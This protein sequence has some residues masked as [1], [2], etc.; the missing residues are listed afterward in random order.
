MFRAS[1]DQQWAQRHFLRRLVVRVLA[2]QEM[3]Q[4]LRSLG[5][6]EVFNDG[7][8]ITPDELFW[9]KIEKGIRECDAFVVVLSHALV[10]SYWVDSEVQFARDNG[11]KVIPVRIDDCKLPASFD[12]RDVIDLR[13]GRDYKVKLAPSRITKHSPQIL[14]GRNHW[15]DALDAAWVNPAFRDAG[16]MDYLPSGLLTAALYHFVRG[17]AAAARTALDQ[18][19]QIAERGPMPLYL[20]D[21]HLHR[22]RFF[23]DNSERAKA[24]EL[25]EKHG[26]GRRKEELEDAEAAAKSWP[27]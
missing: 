12:G 25:I 4:Y 13:Q 11:K 3:V 17:E 8:T 19:R 26:Y 23:R 1:R 22:A 15:L 6:D 7:Y 10:R 14:F 21:I 24:R 20:A 16:T 5:Y 27:A 2:R 9:T 18:A